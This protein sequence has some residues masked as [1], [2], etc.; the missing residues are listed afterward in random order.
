MDCQLHVPSRFFQ[1]EKV[2]KHCLG[3]FAKD[4]KYSVSIQIGHL[5]YHLQCST[6]AGQ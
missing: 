4:Y 1:S 3:L 5:A 6:P 2:Q